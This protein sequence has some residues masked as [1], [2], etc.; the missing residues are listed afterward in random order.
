M[1]NI[2]PLRNTV[3]KIKTGIYYFAGRARSTV[4]IVTFL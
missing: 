3:I 1:E 2:N 4:H